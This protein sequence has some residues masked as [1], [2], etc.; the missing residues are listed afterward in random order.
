M[1]LFKIVG[2]R[3]KKSLREVGVEMFGIG[4]GKKYDTLSSGGTIG[5]L[6]T[7]IAFIEMVEQAKE[8]WG[9]EYA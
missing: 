8:V 5:G 6:E 1:K 9:R 4:F 7:T 2:R 3:H